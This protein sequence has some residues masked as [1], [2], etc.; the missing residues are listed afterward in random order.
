MKRAPFQKP[1]Q[2]S[3]RIALYSGAAVAVFAAGL[4]LLISPGGVSTA[5]LHGLLTGIAALAAHVV[6][7]T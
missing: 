2:L 6:W 4:S 3:F 7:V 5:L 1:S